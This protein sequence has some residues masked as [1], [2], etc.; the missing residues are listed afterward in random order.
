LESDVADSSLATN[1]TESEVASVVEGV[2]FEGGANPE[3]FEE[4][5]KGPRLEG[6]VVGEGVE[7]EEEGSGEGEEGEHVS[8]CTYVRTYVRMHACMPGGVVTAGVVRAGS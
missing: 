5:A 1:T 3:A 8:V 7:E 2:G 4:G 6:T